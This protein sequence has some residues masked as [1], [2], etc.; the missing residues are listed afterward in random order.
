MAEV[1]SRP[2]NYNQ[3]DAFLAIYNWLTAGGTSDPSSVHPQTT[4]AASSGATVKVANGV[5]T[6]SGDNVVLAAVTGKK[7]RVLSYALQCQETGTVTARFQDN[8]TTTN[9]TMPWILTAGAS[10]NDGVVR[11]PGDSSHW[12]FETASGV[13][14]DLNLS[15][16]LDTGWE[17]TYIEV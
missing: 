7:I 12:Y 17:I 4:G 6:A 8:A 14:L 16:A 10:Q 3:E 9:R 13:G 1:L 15:S 2:D 11:N 5:A